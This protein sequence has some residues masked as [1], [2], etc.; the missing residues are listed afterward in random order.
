MKSYLYVKIESKNINNCLIK[1]R[2]NKINILSVKY[3]SKKEAII[4]IKE[5]DYKKLMKLKSNKITII[6]SRGLIKF[7]ELFNKYKLTFIIFIISLILLVFLSNVI[8]SIDVVTD[9]KL[10]KDKIIKEL[11]SYGIKKYKLKKNYKNIQIIKEDILKNHK[12]DIEW[13]EI[14]EYG[15]SYTIK[16]VERKKNI[17]KEE[18]GSTNIVARKPGIIKSIIT[19]SGETILL[20]DNYVNKDEII[21]SGT[22]MLNDKIKATVKSKGKVY[23]ETWYKVNITL[24]LNYKEIKYTKNKKRTI[25]LKISNKYYELFKYKNNKREDIISYNNKLIPISIG[26]ENIKEIK[27]INKKYSLKEAKKKALD[28]AKNSVIQKLDDDSYIMDEK[29]LKFYSNS[30]KIEM[31]IF[32]SVYENIAKEIENNIEKIEEKEE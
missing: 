7:K 4:L 2:K 1:L 17:I 9:N 22:L 31:E 27:Y 8:F 21:I 26:L 13:I 20:E 28:L 23:A 14:S 25:Y 24:P 18:S 15:T 5:E 10:L 16:I 6:N 32:I 3:L 12:N 30:S 19:E 29:T 11:N